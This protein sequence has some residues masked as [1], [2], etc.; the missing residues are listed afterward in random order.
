[1]NIRY[2]GTGASIASIAKE[3]KVSASTVSRALHGNPS[4]SLETQARV[5]DVARRQG[6]IPNPLLAKVFSEIRE[7]RVSDFRGML[8]WV[9]T[10]PESHTVTPDPVCQAFFRGANEQAK[11]MGFG[12]DRF[13]MRTMGHTGKRLA[14][15]LEARGITGLVILPDYDEILSGKCLE[16]F[17]FERFSAACIGAQLPRVRISSAMSDQHLMARMAHQ[18]MRGLGYKRVGLILWSFQAELMAGRLTGGFRSL[19]GLDT[20]PV[21]ILGG[22]DEAPVRHVPGTEMPELKEVEKFIK[23]HN[24]DGIVTPMYTNY[25]TS[26]LERLHGNGVHVGFCSLD[27]QGENQLA[28]VEQMHEQVASMA[29]ESVV[30]NLVHRSSGILVMERTVLI[31]GEWHAGPSAPGPHQPE[32]SVAKKP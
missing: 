20:A 24:L 12:L 29:V 4:I 1:M 6:Y 26:F 28:G 13:S 5:K 9:D 25:F 18:S 11:R 27:R 3:A 7:H 31:E 8:A 30:S 32:K 15:V 2:S 16:G 10:L 19:R 21:L 23:H 14:D 17:P 22:E